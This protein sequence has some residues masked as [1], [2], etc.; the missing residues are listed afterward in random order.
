MIEVATLQA[1]GDPDMGHGTFCAPDLTTYCGLGELGLVVVA[2]R[3]VAPSNNEAGVVQVLR[4]LL[5]L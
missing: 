4:S 3:F 2:A 5:G 1:L